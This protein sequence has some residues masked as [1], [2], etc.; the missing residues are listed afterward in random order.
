MAAI[1]VVEMNMV[2]AR[3]LLGACFLGIGLDFVEIIA[4]ELDC[5][6]KR[7]NCQGVFPSSTATNTV[8]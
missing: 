4:R 8:K 2:A 5:V 1:K 7:F 3:T 6:G